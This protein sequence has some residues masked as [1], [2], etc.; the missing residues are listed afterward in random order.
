MT[1]PNKN[2]LTVSDDFTTVVADGAYVHL[3]EGFC[4]L[5][6]FRDNVFPIHD[7]EGGLTKEDKRRTVLH[8]V[9]LAIP[10]IEMLKDDLE[11][12]LKGHTALGLVDDD[13]NIWGTTTFEPGQELIYTPEGEEVDQAV[14]NAYH[15]TWRSV[16]REGKRKLRQ[17]AIQFVYDNM[18]EIR[19]IAKQYPKNDKK[20]AKV[21]AASNEQPTK[22]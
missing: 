4:V 20:G 11:G 22:V 21:R 9:R 15:D 1:L 18:E 17:L 7:V 8:E 14:V 6:F 16:S 12:A 13:R 3:V 10:A 5:L 19:T 2:D